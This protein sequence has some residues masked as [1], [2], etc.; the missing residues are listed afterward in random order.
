MSPG[1]F[2]FSSALNLREGYHSNRS[3]C[4]GPV[5]WVRAFW[6]ECQRHQLSPGIPVSKQGFTQ[7]DGK[8]WW[9]A[10]LVGPGGTALL[11]GPLCRP[12]CGQL[13]P[14]AQPCSQITTVNV[15]DPG[16]GFGIVPVPTPPNR[17]SSGQNSSS[18]LLRWNLLASTS[19]KL[20]LT[21]LTVWTKCSGNASQ[22]GLHRGAACFSCGKCFSRHQ[23]KIIT[24][25]NTQK[26]LK[27]QFHWWAFVFPAKFPA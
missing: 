19:T 18:C 2:G 14:L 1:V 9:I 26:K 12:R 24:S 3:D 10:A 16:R 7:E 25:I 20:M 21:P 22:I 11:R 27:I 23:I 6:Q 4:V 15:V 5:L 8:P 17:L 13:G